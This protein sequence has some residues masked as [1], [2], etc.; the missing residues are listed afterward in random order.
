MTLKGFDK[1]LEYTIA[2]ETQDNLIEYFDWGLLEK[3]NYFNVTLGEQD[4]NGNDYSLLKPT[5]NTNFLAGEA[6]EGFRK[7]WVWQSGVGFD[8]EPLVG[9]DDSLPGISGIYVDNVFY[10]S[11]TA[12]AYAHNVDYFNGRVI[13]DNPIPTGS[14]VQAEYS[15]KY[16]SV[17]YAASVPW[18]RELYINSMDLSNRDNVK[19]PTE[20]QIQLPAIAIEIVPT[21]TLKGYQLGPSGQF[22]NTDVLFHCI[23]EDDMTRNKLI[24]I[25]SMQND[26]TVKM[27]D[28]NKIADSGAFPLNSFGY[29]V[30]GAPR[31]PELVDDYGCETFRMKDTTVQAV[32]MINSNLYAGVVRI[33]TELI[34]TKF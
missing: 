28:S 7:N 6:W 9:S 14:K 8:P 18:L 16:I 27:F 13:F 23:A 1:I 10:P 26:S 32:D 5:N 31:Y 21:R 33:T 11:D 24:D 2:N 12:G 4:Y 22:V 15:Y 34:S 20:M 25:V 17:I 30:S 3:G 19:V 29:T